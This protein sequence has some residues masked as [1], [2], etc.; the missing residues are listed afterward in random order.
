IPTHQRLSFHTLF[1]LQ[2]A[3]R[4]IHLLASG[5]AGLGSTGFCG[6]LR[7]HRQKNLVLPALETTPH[8]NSASAKKPVENPFVLLG[9]N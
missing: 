4:F 1:L 8:R 5:S 3:P 7:L 6:V 9:L 2:S